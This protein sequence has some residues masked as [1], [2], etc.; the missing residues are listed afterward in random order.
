VNVIFYCDKHPLHLWICLLPPSALTPFWVLFSPILQRGPNDEGQ[1]QKHLL[2]AHR[3]HFMLSF[4]YTPALYI[5]MQRLATFLSI[6]ADRVYV[7][8]KFLVN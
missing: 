3:R 8:R 5:R 1:M 4:Y 7:E 2:L 6:D